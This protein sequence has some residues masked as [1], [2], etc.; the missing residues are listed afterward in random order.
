MR[1]QLALST[2]IPTIVLSVCL[3][4]GFISW[5]LL[6]T[7]INHL[8]KQA[9]HDKGTLTLE[10]LT[11]LVI[12]PLFNSDT[13]SV[14]V[15]LKKVTQDS[16][17]ISASL[18]G[19]D[20]ELISQSAKPEPQTLDAQ[21]FTRN[22]ELQNTQIGIISVVV[23][24]KPIDQQYQQPF[25]NWLILWLSFTLIATYLS[26]RFV[27][28]LSLRIRRLNDRLPGNTEPMSDE[29]STLETKVQ[30]L[31][32]SVSESEQ[33][34]SNTYYYSLITA[35]IKNR[36]RLGNQLSQ[37]NL[38]ILFEKL[39]Y[40]FLRTLQLYGGTRVDGDP[41]SICFTIRSTQ[42]TKQHL[43]VCLMAAYSLR[44]LIENLSLQHGVDLEINWTLNSQDISTS[45]QFYFEQGIAEIRHNNLK[46]AGQLQAGL[47]VL[48]CEN[49]SIN[50][51]S[52]IAHFATYDDHYYLLEGFSENR[53]QLLQTQLQHLTSLCLGNG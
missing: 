48:H 43:L 37:T 26:H 49:Y 23:D 28:Q 14:Q 50:D 27:D 10:R 15:A 2:K 6:S 24:R 39:D 19:V 1:R 31:L 12:T 44:Q 13:I 52:S 7:Q 53:Q 21:I 47:I 30:P 45:P 40:C 5:L 16:S 8:A 4:F 32:S 33:D 11:E 42:C 22:L 36:Q 38:D 41:E 17:I 35:H 46:L 20:G 9:V 25:I 51:L 18:F 29:L 34:S 3:T